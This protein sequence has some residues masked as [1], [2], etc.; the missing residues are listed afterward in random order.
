MLRVTPE[1]PLLQCDDATQPASAAVPA[2]VWGL[3]WREVVR[4]IAPARDALT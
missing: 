4:S 1:E 2:G 3:A